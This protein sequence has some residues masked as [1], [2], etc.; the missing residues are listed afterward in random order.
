MLQVEHKLAQ[1]EGLN[2]PGLKCMAHKLL[3]CLTLSL[4]SIVLFFSIAKSDD[5]LG[6]CSGPDMAKSIAACSALLNSSA[7]NEIKSQ[8]L[9]QRGVRYQASQQI[10][11]AIADFDQSIQLNPQN[12]LS[13]AA[14]GA[15]YIRQENFEV[16]RRDIDNAISLQPNM[17]SAFVARGLLNLNSGNLDGAISDSTEALRLDP[18]AQAAYNNRG[19]A[20]REKGEYQKAIQD[21]N[22]VIRLNPTLARPLYNR[23]LTYLRSGDK[24]HAILDYNAA[25]QLDP[26]DQDVIAGLKA[27]AQTESQDGT[28]RS[29]IELRPGTPSQSNFGTSALVT[30]DC[31]KINAAKLNFDYVDGRDSF[32]KKNFS[33]PISAWTDEDVTNY[34]KSLTTCFQEKQSFRNY[35]PN[36]FYSQES[37]YLDKLREMV[38]FESHQEI[39][40]QK[41]QAFVAESQQVLAPWV[42]RNPHLIEPEK[43]EKEAAVTSQAD[44]DRL[45]AI[46]IEAK[47]IQSENMRN[48]YLEIQGVEGIPDQ[49]EKALGVIRDNQRFGEENKRERAQ[50]AEDE[51]GAEEASIRA[52]NMYKL[53]K[54][55]AEKAGFTLMSLRDLLLERTKLSGKQIAVQ[56]FLTVKLNSAVLDYPTIGEIG[57]SFLA[58]VRPTSVFI[59]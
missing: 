32:F 8:A 52:N 59:C 50:R 10:D 11:K 45:K 6:E 2:C 41:T 17:S 34:G 25:S 42:N 30:I 40:R 26:S 27:I 53:A 22:V 39:A 9:F 38:R 37:K 1:K 19:A 47:R 23:G 49:V 55:D 33:K 31:N 12:A 28:A 43:A 35:Q 7:S 13:F 29:G 54:D 51:K 4:A 16:A 14:R 5:V 58:A 18:K 44:I 56:G 48:G 24:D 21:L 57:V 46:A 15:A 3:R 36:Y 20:F